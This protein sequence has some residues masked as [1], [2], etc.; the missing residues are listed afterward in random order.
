MAAAFLGA[1]LGAAF[2]AGAGAFLAGGE[3]CNRTRQHGTRSKVNGDDPP[4][5]QR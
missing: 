2:L 5:C 4:P 1:S 3:F